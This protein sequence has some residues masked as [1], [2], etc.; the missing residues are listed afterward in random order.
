M[1]VPNLDSYPNFF[2][3]GVPHPN[4]H[5]IRSLSI[6]EQGKAWPCNWAGGLRGS[7]PGPEREPSQPA[8]FACRAAASRTI[9]YSYL[10][11]PSFDLEGIGSRNLGKAWLGERVGL[12]VVPCAP[13]P[14]RGRRGLV[15]EPQLGLVQAMNGRRLRK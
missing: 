2:N 4:N 15:S 5:P 9:R 7:S 11:V 3:G 14:Q 1:V 8:S 6:D 10:T 12:V 13:S